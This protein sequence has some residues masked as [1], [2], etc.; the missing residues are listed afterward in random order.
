[1]YLMF[2]LGREDVFP[3]EDLGIRHAMTEPH[4]YEDRVEMVDHTEAWCPYRTHA[5]VVLWRAIE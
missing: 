5:R 4:G 1:M 2:V 3:F